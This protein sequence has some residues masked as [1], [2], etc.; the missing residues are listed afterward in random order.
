VAEP[1]PRRHR[2]GSPTSTATARRRSSA[3]ARS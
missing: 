2:V 3:G 1:G